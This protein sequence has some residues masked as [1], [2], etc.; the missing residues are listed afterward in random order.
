MSLKI[1]KDTYLLITKNEL[2]KI[3]INDKWEN[4]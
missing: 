3:G 4:D 2:D 1:G